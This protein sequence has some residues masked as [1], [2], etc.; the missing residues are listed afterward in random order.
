[1]NHFSRKKVEA[2]RNFHFFNVCTMFL[3]ELRSLSKALHAAILL[4][5]LN[6]SQARLG[7][8][9]FPLEHHRMTAASSWD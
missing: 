7:F 4:T 9:S 8:V 1:M 3:S 5:N 6:M 2:A